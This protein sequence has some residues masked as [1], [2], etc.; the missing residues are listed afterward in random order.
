MSLFRTVQIMKG[1]ITIDNIDICHVS[2]EDLRSRLS[3]IPQDTFLFSGTLRENLD[4]RRYFSDHELWDALNTAQLKAF[5]HSQPS[6]LGIKFTF[7]KLRNNFFFIKITDLE[8]KE[9]GINFSVGQRQLICLARSI[10]R[11]SICLILDEA[12]SS[13][14]SSTEAQLLDAVNIAFNGKT[15]INIAVS[16]LLTRYCNNF[17]NFILKIL[18]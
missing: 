1:K 10:L 2:L 5:I 4:P 12:T 8:V 13:L 7:K 9:G 17:L 3:I 11:G 18:L 14:D 15:V 16:T 6:G